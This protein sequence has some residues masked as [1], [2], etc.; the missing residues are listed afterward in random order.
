ME[1]SLPNITLPLPETGAEKSPALTLLDVKEINLIKPS[2]LRKLVRDTIKTILPEMYSE[3]AVELIMMTAAQ[4]SL[5]GR[6]LQQQE[7]GIALGIF[8]I[9]P[10]TYRDIFDNHLA[11]HP[12]LKARVD[13]HFAG[14][15]MENFSIMLRG[16]IPYSIVLCRIDYWREREA[17]PAADDIEGLASYY[18]RFWNSSLGDADIKTA[19]R[20]YNKYAK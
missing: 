11:Y 8:Q 7:N 2:Q 14:I 19:I 15:N 13:A 18:K 16:N 20:N 9:E 4:E 12:K 5:C 6:Y 1:K 17:L 3:A 10:P